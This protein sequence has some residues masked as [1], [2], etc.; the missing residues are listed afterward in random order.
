MLEQLDALERASQHGWILST[1]QLAELIGVTGN[2]LSR[3]DKPFERHG[4]L[5]SRSGIVGDQ[6][7]WKVE[8]E[9]AAKK[10]KGD[11]G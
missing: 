6:L 9:P 4:F 3:W 5:I 8:K 2:T 10:K 1:G 11:R 7:G